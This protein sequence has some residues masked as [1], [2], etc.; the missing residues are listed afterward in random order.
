M[1]TST[2][3]FTNLILPYRITNV[4]ESTHSPFTSGSGSATKTIDPLSIK[5]VPCQLAENRD[6]YKKYL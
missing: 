1:E 4:R 3:V 5:Q 2:D 6:I